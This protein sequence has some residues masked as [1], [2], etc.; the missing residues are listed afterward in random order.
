[1]A[2]APLPGNQIVVALDVELTEE[3]EAEGR[4]RDMVRAIQQMRKDKGFHPTDRIRLNYS[5]LPPGVEQHLD[6]ISREVLAVETTKCEGI[7]P[8]DGYSVEG[9]P[10][11]VEIEQIEP[12]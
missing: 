4:A 12:A 8:N 3:L 6:W 1:M 7:S 11:R 5:E 9:Q 10:L 2:A